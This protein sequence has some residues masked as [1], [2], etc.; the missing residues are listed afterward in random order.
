MI[1]LLTLFLMQDAAEYYNKGLADWHKGDY[2]SAIANCT[3][4]IELDPKYA[5]AWY[6]R[7]VTRSVKADT[8]GAIADFSKRIELDFYGWAYK[9]RGFLRFDLGQYAEALADLHKGCEVH[10]SQQNYPQLYIFL[11]RARQGDRKEAE[12]GLSEYMKSP[13]PK[14]PWHAKIVDF[15][16]GSLSADELLKAAEAGDQKATRSQK[17]EAHFYIGSLLLIQGDKVKAKDHFKKC[18][19][20]DEKTFPEYMSARAGLKRLEKD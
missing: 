14:N 18:L 11:I 7:G 10:S 13:K 9:R 2:D 16:L 5:E 6:Q 19:E 1:V 15:F 12:Q 3:K 20:T 8:E 4:A 17:C